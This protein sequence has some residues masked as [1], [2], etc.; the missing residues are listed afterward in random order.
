MDWGS[1]EL[2]LDL[3]VLDWGSLE[4]IPGL[5]GPVPLLVPDETVSFLL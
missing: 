3:I 2:I 1:L 4:L 5:T